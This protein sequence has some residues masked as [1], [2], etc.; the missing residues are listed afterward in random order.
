M[1]KLEWRISNG[2]SRSLL[3]VQ[4]SKHV[5]CRESQFAIRDSSFETHKRERSLV[6]HQRVVD[7]VRAGNGEYPPRHRARAERQGRMAAASQVVSNR[8]PRAAPCAHAWVV[9]VGRSRGES[10]PRKG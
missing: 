6:V 3:A 5:R 4:A 1:A 9:D 7:R 10:Q 8:A 2:E